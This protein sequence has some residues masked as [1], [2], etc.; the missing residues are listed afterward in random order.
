MA[1]GPIQSP[2]SHSPNNNGATLSAGSIIFS[3]ILCFVDSGDNSRRYNII[4]I[5]ILQ[6]YDDRL[7]YYLELSEFEATSTVRVGYAPAGSF[8]RSH[9]HD[10][11]LMSQHEKAQIRV[12][13]GIDMIG[14][15]RCIRGGS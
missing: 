15:F 9:R 3:Q 13:Q 6:H 7:I 8:C 4:V 2:P 1:T 11:T 5:I 14:F 10:V 12:L